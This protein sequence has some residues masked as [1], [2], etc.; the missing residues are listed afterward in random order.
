MHQR[1]VQ[2]SN[3]LFLFY[4]ILAVGKEKDLG[5]SRNLFHLALD[6]NHFLK[7]L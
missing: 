6:E 2:R 3:S 5:N 4:E 7:R 1:K